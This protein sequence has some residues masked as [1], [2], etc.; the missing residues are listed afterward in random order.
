MYSLL[1]FFRPVEEEDPAAA[2]SATADQEGE[3]EGE[4]E[5]DVFYANDPTGQSHQRQG[6]EAFLSHRD[7]REGVEAVAGAG[8]MPVLWADIVR[9]VDAVVA[10]GRAAAGGAAGCA[11]CE[12]SVLAVDLLVAREEGKPPRPWIVDVVE[13]PSFAPYPTPNYPAAA[14]ADADA[15]VEDLM[16]LLLARATRNSTSAPSKGEEIAEAARFG[17][18]AAAP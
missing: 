14:A 3:G 1:L 16:N 6:G 2:G 4:G 13:Q 9:A 12:H 18:E 10:A 5:G 15:F 17:F 8:A 7:V 11:G